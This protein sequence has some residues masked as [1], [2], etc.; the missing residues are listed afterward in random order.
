M[1]DRGDPS[2]KKLLK[3]RKRWLSLLY[4][5]PFLCLV[6]KCGLD[7]YQGINSRQ[8]LKGETVIDTAVVIDEVHFFPN[9]HIS[10]E[11]TY[12]YQFEFSGKIYKGVCPDSSFL[13]GDKILIDVVAESPEI[14]SYHGFYKDSD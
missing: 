2:K 11:H 4:L 8:L 12:M 14:N 3:R 9:G 10:D 7:I 6:G 13:P 1:Q 5:L